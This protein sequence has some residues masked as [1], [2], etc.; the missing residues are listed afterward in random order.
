MGEG[1]TCDESRN[2]RNL[3]FVIACILHNLCKPLTILYPCAQCRAPLCKVVWCTAM[4]PTECAYV[5]TLP[6]VCV[7]FNTASQSSVSR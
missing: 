3:A 5:A 4:H 2:L 6:C 1:G 7:T